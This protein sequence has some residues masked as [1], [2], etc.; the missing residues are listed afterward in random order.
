MLL[1]LTYKI[2]LDND[3]DET[4]TTYPETTWLLVDAGDIRCQL[5]DEVLNEVTAENEGPVTTEAS[6]LVPTV[7]PDLPILAMAEERLL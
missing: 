4:D 3:P 5:D 1:K 6:L 2:P 7:G